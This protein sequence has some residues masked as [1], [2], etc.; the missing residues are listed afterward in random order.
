[1]QRCLLTNDNHIKKILFRFFN[2]IFIFIQ[3]RILFLLNV[4]KYTLKNEI[5]F[6]EINF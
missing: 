1:M 5:I 2:A 3:N 6:I 4:E